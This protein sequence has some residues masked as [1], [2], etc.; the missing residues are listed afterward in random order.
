MFLCINCINSDH[1]PNHCILPCIIIFCSNGRLRHLVAEQ[2][3]RV[4]CYIVLWEK[5]IDLLRRFWYRFTLTFE[6]WT[7]IGSSYL[8]DHGDGVVQ[9]LGCPD[10][11]CASNPN[12]A[13]SNTFL[14]DRCLP[15]GC[16][17]T[18]FADV[19]SGNLGNWIHKDCV[20]MCHK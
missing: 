10:A 3:V 17:W 4:K 5:S 19:T 2:F 7:Y 13:S 18:R 8:L 14:C 6:R 1:F 16:S 11:C 20:G 9:W 15:Y 12:N